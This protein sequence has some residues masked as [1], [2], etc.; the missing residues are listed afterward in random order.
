MKIPTIDPVSLPDAEELASV[1]SYGTAV[2]PG[3]D[4]TIIL[5]ASMIYDS[6]VPPVGQP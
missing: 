3:H 2:T 4:D 6:V 5:L 1:L